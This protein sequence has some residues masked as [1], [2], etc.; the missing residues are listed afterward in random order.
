MSTSGEKR[1]DAYIEELKKFSSRALKNVIASVYI[2]CIHLH[3]PNMKI[4]NGVKNQLVYLMYIYIKATGEAMD[5]MGD[6]EF[7]YYDEAL[8]ILKKKLNTESIEYKVYKLITLV[9][10]KNKYIHRGLST[11]NLIEILRNHGISDEVVFEQSSEAY[12]IFLSVLSESA[13]DDY[14]GDD[15]KGNMKPKTI[16][17]AIRNLIRNLK[18]NDVK[19]GEFDDLYISL[20][21]SSNMF[22]TNQR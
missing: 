10:K 13:I 15:S 18:D 6:Y 12:L 9:L 11:E 16:N 19:P 3:Y 2:S 14:L 22:K 1:N 17:T 7:N 21:Q 4:G 20:R 8:E 5:A